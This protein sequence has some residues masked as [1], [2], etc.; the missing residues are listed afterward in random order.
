[1]FSGRTASSGDRNAEEHKSW[2]FLSIDQTGKV[3][4][5]SITKVL[6]FYK[7]SKHIIVDPTKSN[8]PTYTSV[9]SR[10]TSRVQNEGFYDD[11]TMVA[12]GNNERVSVLEL[13]P[14]SHTELFSILR[15]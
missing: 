1:M 4:V 5:N 11:M 15:P 12:I 10:F 7:A 6:L 14:G 13:G 9:A 2:M 3:V 8:W